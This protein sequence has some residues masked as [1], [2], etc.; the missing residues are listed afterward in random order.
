MTRQVMWIPNPL[1]TLVTPGGL[2]LSD[3]D[4]AEA[5]SDSL[6][7]H[8]QPVIDTS[9]PAII[10]VVNK[11]LRAYS[12]APASE[13]KLTNPT[14]FQDAI[15]GLKV[16]KAPGSAVFRIGPWRIFHQVSFPSSLCYLKQFF[17]RSTSRRLGSTH[18]CFGSWNLARIW[19]YSH[20]IDP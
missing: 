20:L 18:A 1:P 19:R 15:R 12:L 3:S 4:K 6:E 2:A 8:F 7:A 9:V 5:F 16:G 13:P 17:E 10:E 14:D 11:A